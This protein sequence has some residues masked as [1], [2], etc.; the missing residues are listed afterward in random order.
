M[1]VVILPT[2]HKL[3]KTL[4]RNPGKLSNCLGT[5]TTAYLNLLRKALKAIALMLQLKVRTTSVHPVNR[6]ARQK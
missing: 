2:W 1:Y 6:L 5:F 4:I 3:V